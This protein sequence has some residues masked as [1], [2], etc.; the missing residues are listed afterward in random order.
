M[1]YILTLLSTILFSVSV[2]SQEYEENVVIQG[3]LVSK[4][5][6]PLSDALIGVVDADIQT[7]TDQNGEF[8]LI[9]PVESNLYFSVNSKDYNTYVNKF[10]SNQKDNRQTYTFVTDFKQ[11]G[12]QVSL[13]NSK[14]FLKERL[15]S[16]LFPVAYYDSNIEKITSRRLGQY[17]KDKD[18]KIIFIINGVLYTVSGVVG[19]SVEKMIIY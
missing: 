12:R 19:E 14:I 4:D 9:C 10:I 16:P 17:E 11:N 6:C 13:T 1:K 7:R 15:Y 5:K 18:S 3:I 8:T 2:I